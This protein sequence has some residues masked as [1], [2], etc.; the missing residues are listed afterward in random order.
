M[1]Q[2]IDMLMREEDERVKGAAR[3][4]VDEELGKAAF[5]RKVNIIGVVGLSE[6]RLLWSPW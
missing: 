2:V 4:T 5:N 1:R 3:H 6:R